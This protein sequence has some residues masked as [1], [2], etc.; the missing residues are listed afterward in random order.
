MNKIFFVNRFYSPDYSATSQLLTDA[1]EYLAERREVHIVTSRLGYEGTQRFP[2]HEILNGVVV[3]RVWTTGFGRSNLIGRAFDYLSFYVSVFFKLLSLIDANSL[4]VAKTDPPMVSIPVSW[5]AAIR[6]AKLANW[7]QDLFPEVA[8]SLDYRLPDLLVG[9][10]KYFRNRSLQ[11]AALNI[12]IGEMMRTRVLKEGVYTDRVVVV[13]NWSDGNAIV[14]SES[15]ALR[16]Q[17]NLTEQFVVGYSGNLGQAHDSMTLLGAIEE[18]ADADMTFLFIGGGSKLEAIRDGC[19]GNCQFQPYQ[20]RDR[21]PESLTVPDIH[22]VSLLPELEGLILPSK[23][24]GILAA[25]RPL[26]NIG[27]PRGEVGKLVE[28]NNIGFNIEVS[29]PKELVSLLKSLPKRTDEL[30]SMGITARA[31][32]EERFSRDVALRKLEAALCQIN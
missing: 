14:P 6:G 24:Y 29:D 8:V 15:Q 31:L 3:H 5:A 12:A 23:V 30:K 32:F 11:T 27:N 1:A 16:R 18:L 19:Y 20:R 13:P 9:L 4:V 7:L 26:I 28:E 2:A 17:W 10:M 21:L 22:L 25:G